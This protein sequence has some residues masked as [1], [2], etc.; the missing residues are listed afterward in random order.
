MKFTIH[1]PMLLCVLVATRLVAQPAEAPGDNQ[2]PPFL[3]VWKDTKGQPEGIKEYNRW[4][5]RQ[6]V[7][8]D[9]SPATFYSSAKTWVEVEFPFNPGWGQWMAGIPAHRAILSATLLPA[10]GSTLALG[11]AGAYTSHFTALA[12]NLA[13]NHLGQTIICLGPTSDQGVPW[14]VSNATDARNFSLYWRRIVTAM[15]A[16]PGAEKL[17]F[18]WVAPTRKP[19]YAVEDAYPGGDYVDYI[20]YV[21]EEGTDNARIYPYP[22][23]ASESEQLYRQKEAWDL[24]ESPALQTWCAFAQAHGKPFS[25]PRWNLTGGHTRTMG[26]DAPY[27]IQAVHD[28]IQDPAHH[29]YFTSFYEFYHGSWLS[30]TNGYQTVFPKSAVIFHQLF[31]LPGS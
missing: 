6:K 1:L 28:Y 23:F 14:K 26:F 22:P 19:G 10:D 27:F 9:L 29:V 16:V 8:P 5:N 30:P 11:A 24:V 13:A 7:W 31:A 25:I 4:L 18:D 21:I 20:G 12:R 15:R 3:A 2:K 17:Q